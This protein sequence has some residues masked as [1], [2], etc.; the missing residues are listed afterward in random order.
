MEDNALNQPQQVNSANHEQKRLIDIFQKQS[1]LDFIDG[2][3]EKDLDPDVSHEDTIKL[4]EKEVLGLIEEFEEN[5]PKEAVKEF[6]DTVKESVPEAELSLEKMR[7]FMR[8][9]HIRLSTKILNNKKGIGLRK[10][11]SIVNSLKAKTISEEAKI[12]RI[13][14]ASKKE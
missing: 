7:I 9:A 4:K 3:L 5:W 2:R 10:D 11:E 14:H 12:I 1:I 6:V 8:D 13:N